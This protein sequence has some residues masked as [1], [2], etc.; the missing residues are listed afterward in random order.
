[1]DADFISYE[2]MLAAR[3]SAKWAYWGMIAAMVSALAMLA[4]LF[5]AH[6]ALST[7]REQEK[8]KVKLDF[9]MAIKQLK[10]SLLFMPITIDPVEIEEEREQVIA[11]WIFKDDA[12]LTQQIELGEQNVK[13]FD[14]LIN[15]FDNCHSAWLATEHLF[16]N[17]DLAKNWMICEDDFKKYIS[18][19][20]DKTPLLQTINK[21]TETRFVFESK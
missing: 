8:A 14:E 12:L 20:S 21:I 6:K 13:R 9:R 3:D 1:M 19:E 4:T 2:S 17:T 15:S 18:G 7:W 11:K 16:D 5:F 10:A